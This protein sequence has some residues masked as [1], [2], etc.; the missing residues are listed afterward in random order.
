[1]KRDARLICATVE[2]NL[3]N[4]VLDTKGQTLYD[5]NEV[6]KAVKFAD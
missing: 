6:P 4:T 2:M 1:M 3:E 5:S